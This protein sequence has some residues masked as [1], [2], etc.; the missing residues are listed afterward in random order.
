M[1]GSA[2]G[3]DIPPDDGGA[4]AVGVFGAIAVVFSW[5]VRVRGAVE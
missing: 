1:G 5:N 3:Q 2:R 4:R